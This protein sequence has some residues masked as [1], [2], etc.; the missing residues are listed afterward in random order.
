MEPWYE[1]SSPSESEVEATMNR[2]D[3]YLCLY[4]EANTEEENSYLRQ[5]VMNIISKERERAAPLNDYHM[6]ETFQTISY[7]S[8][9]RHPDWKKLTTTILR[10]EVIAH[11]PYGSWR[12]FSTFVIAPLREKFIIRVIR[13][14]W[15][16]Y[17]LQTK[18]IPVWLNHNYS[19]YGASQGYL[20]TKEHYD[21]IQGKN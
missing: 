13:E 6:D 2:S 7:E 10:E 4:K 18:F 12:G 17:V 16:P 11:K 8:I 3:V 15:A 14:I 20:R 21:A 1:A 9:R 19:P 5:V